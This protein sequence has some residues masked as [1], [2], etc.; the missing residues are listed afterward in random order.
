MIIIEAKVLNE[1]ICP[2]VEMIF[3]LRLEASMPPRKKA[4]LI[5]PMAISLEPAS[6]RCTPTK[7]MIM[8]YPIAKKPMAIKSEEMGSAENLSL[9]SMRNLCAIK[10]VV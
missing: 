9:A 1:R 5:S 7:V 3:W 8:L 10:G 6:L 2:T 4:A